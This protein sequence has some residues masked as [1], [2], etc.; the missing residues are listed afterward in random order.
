MTKVMATGV[1]DIL[2]LG[3]IDYL[4]QSRA[5]GE[6]LIVVVATDL[7]AQKSGKKLVFS[8]NA[9]RE[10]VSNLKMVNE[11]VV[12]NH[13]DIFR[14][15]EILKP[16]IITLGFDQR[17]DEKQIEDECAKRNIHVKVV[18]C[19]R[20]ESQD[21]VGTRMIKKRIIELEGIRA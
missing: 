17:F 6:E 19:K 14:T 20:F 10:M 7:N 5:L 9:R 15:V 2:H 16:D 1:F 21:P 8:E 3:H 11:A 12:G 13:G 4:K 18:R